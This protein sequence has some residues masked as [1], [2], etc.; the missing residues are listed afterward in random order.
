MIVG[1]VTTDGDPVVTID[2]HGARRFR[3]EAI[4]DTGFTGH[5]C[6]A[7]RY[8]K[9]VRLVRLGDIESELADGSCVTQPEYAAEVSFDGE[10]RRVLVML[11]DSRDSLI[12]TALLRKKRVAIDFP[13]RRVVVR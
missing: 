6:L 8:E 12:G 2:I 4:L 1:H 11:T 9:R 7:R 13:R 10:R 5:L 3:I